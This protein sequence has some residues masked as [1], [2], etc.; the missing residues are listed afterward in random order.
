MLELF[1]AKSSG[2]HSRPCPLE[3]KYFRNVGTTI[4]LP[5]SYLRGWME[6]EVQTRAKEEMG[7][8]LRESNKLN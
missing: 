8:F 6:K 2:T 5:E 1:F 4:A 3:S 7:M